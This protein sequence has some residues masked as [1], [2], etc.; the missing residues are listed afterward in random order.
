MLAEDAELIKWLGRGPLARATLGQLTTLLSLWDAQSVAAQHDHAS[1]AVNARQK[2]ERLE[3]GLDLGPLTQLIRNRTQLTSTGREVATEF[4]VLAARLFALSQSNQPVV[5]TLVIGSVDALIQTAISPLA[6]FMARDKT[7]RWRILSLRASD[8]NRGL[9][10]GILHFGVLRSADFVPGP[11]VEELR[12]YPGH[13]L[14]ILAGKNIGISDP[15][16]LLDRLAAEPAHF[17]QQGSSWAPIRKRIVERW[18]VG[19]LFS[20]LEPAVACDTHAQAAAAIGDDGW[21][22]VPAPVARMLARP[23]MFQRSLKLTD[24]TDD[25]SLVASARHG[26]YSGNRGRLVETLKRKL[27]SAL[28]GSKAS[29]N[30]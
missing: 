9:A 22:I 29:L 4:R 11:H 7:S 20:Q 14:A 6:A 10:E 27:G 19:G 23:G 24:S 2:I 25:V 16:A 30:I 1:G 28:R 15:A 21:T 12:R 17:I 13:D 26:T 8:I 3:E 18:S 5:P